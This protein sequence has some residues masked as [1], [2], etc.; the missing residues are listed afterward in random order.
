[1]KGREGTT[2]LADP[3]RHR[4]KVKQVYQHQCRNTEII[5]TKSQTTQSPVIKGTEGGLLT[6]L[7]HL[8]TELK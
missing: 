8:V 2:N 3:P 7:I 4:V 5:L 1:M 6:L